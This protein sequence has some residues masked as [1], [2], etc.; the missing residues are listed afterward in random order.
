MDI[1]KTYW[2]L[3]GSNGRF[4]I[5]VFQKVISPPFPATLCHCMLNDNQFCMLCYV[6]SALFKYLDMNVDDHIDLSEMVRGVALFCRKP[7]AERIQGNL[8]AHDVL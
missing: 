5:G 1:E 6:L 8:L 2:S 3:K 7:F 4:D